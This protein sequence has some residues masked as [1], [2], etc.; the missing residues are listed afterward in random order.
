MFGIEFVVMG[1]VRL[2]GWLVGWLVT[3]DDDEEGIVQLVG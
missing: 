1:E 2:V 3:E